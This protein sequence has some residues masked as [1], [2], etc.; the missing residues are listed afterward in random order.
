MISP[1]CATRVRQCGGAPSPP[2]SSCFAAAAAAAEEHDRGR[3]F[4]TKYI[5][6]TI[7]MGSW[8]VHIRGKIKRQQNIC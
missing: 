6:E 5:I 3:L 7:D 8:G 2:K 4:F 1:R